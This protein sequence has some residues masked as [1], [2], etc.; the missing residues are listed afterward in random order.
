VCGV[1]YRIECWLNSLQVPYTVHP[2]IDLC[3]MA[4][5]GSCSGE[6]VFHF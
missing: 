5:T 2:K 6:F 4:E 1:I 3:R